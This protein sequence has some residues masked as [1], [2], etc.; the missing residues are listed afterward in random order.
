MKLLSRLNYLHY[1]DA[2]RHLTYADLSAFGRHATS[3]ELATF[4]EQEYSSD[5]YVRA[6]IEQVGMHT[7][8]RVD[9]PM[10]RSDI[11]HTGQMRKAFINLRCRGFSYELF[12]NMTGFPYRLRQRINLRM[13]LIT[14]PTLFYPQSVRAYLRRHRSNHYFAGEGPAIAF[15]LGIATRSAWYVLVMQSD[16]VRRGAASVREHFRGWRKVLFGNIVHQSRQHVENIYLCTESDVLAGCHPDYPSPAQPPDA[17]TAIYNR[18]A[19]DV[20]MKL[21]R[22]KRRLNVQLYD[23]KPAVY[24]RYMYIR[25]LTRGRDVLTS[26]GE[27]L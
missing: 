14:D 10:L 15:A 12:G 27:M 18:T 8:R 23:R 3:E 6:V 19:M 20:G 25:D 26:D 22:L 5:G 17:W 16:V 7:G 13:A 9:V 4:L 1:G 24:A 21:V 2:L 11:K